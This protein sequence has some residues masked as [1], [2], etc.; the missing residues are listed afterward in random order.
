[1]A[2]SHQS[3]KI[4]RSP[5]EAEA[6]GDDACRAAIGAEHLAFMLAGKRDE[7][8]VITS[9]RRCELGVHEPDPG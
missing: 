6:D 2:M 5:G 4:F 9:L 3:R 7:A 8:R 1:M